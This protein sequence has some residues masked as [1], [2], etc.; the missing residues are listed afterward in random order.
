LKERANYLVLKIKSIY[1]KDLLDSEKAT[2]LP[3]R[4]SFFTKYKRAHLNLLFLEKEND[5]KCKI[6]KKALISE[7][8]S[9]DE[10]LFSIRLDR[11]FSEFYN[12]TG[13]ELKKIIDLLYTPI[14][15]EINNI[16]EKHLDK[17]LELDNLIEYKFISQ[18]QW[19]PSWEL[20]NFIISILE[21]EWYKSED[22]D[23]W[24]SDII[25]KLG[26]LIKKKQNN[27]KY[28]INWY[29]QTWLTCSAACLLMILNYFNKEWFSKAKEAEIAKNASS[30][31]MIGQ[32]FSWIW[33]QSLN[34]WLKT[35]LIHSNQDL[36][37]NPWYPQWFFE[38]LMW[39]YWTYLDK[40]INR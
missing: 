35:K 25:K 5:L 37:H 8:H 7:Y 30:E 15:K 27:I 39:E 34:A 9:W 6:Y 32:H 40:F 10:E 23:L 22:T 19:L 20:R 4:G 14:K 21:K 33:L 26:L 28:N 12:K 13:D 29:K 11:D 36:F 16:D 38:V 31:F 18:L 1:W 24:E 3:K 2:L 17:I